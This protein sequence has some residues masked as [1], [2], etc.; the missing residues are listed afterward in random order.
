ME[1]GKDHG[2]NAELQRF[3]TSIPRVYLVQPKIFRDARGLFVET[4][5]RLRFAEIGIVDEFVQDNHSRSARGVLR[6]LHYQLRRP[7]AKLCRVVE[8][9]VLDVAVDIRL[10]SPF[11]GRW[12]SVVLSAEA[13]NQI[14]IPQGFAHGFVAL[15][16]TAQL[17]YKCGDFYDPSDQRGIAW[18]DPDL[19]IAWGTSSP[20]LSERDQ[21]HP[22]LAAIPQEFLPVYAAE[23]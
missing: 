4:Y 20:I 6:G 12:V 2:R 15:S 22:F 9:E 13:Q 23:F 7:Q 18:N 10:G 1:S 11:F 17:L 14:Y 19:N 8:G 16:D 3:E 21:K 5:H